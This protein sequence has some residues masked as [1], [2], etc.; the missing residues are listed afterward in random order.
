MSAGNRTAQAK[1]SKPRPDFPLFPHAVGRWTMKIRGKR[2]YFGPWNDPDGTEGKKLKERDHLHAG[3]KPREEVSAGVTVKIAC[4]CFLNS[5]QKKVD[6]GKMTK[7]S[8]PDHKTACDLIVTKLGKHRLVADLDP[9]DF[10]TLRAKMAKKWEPVTLGNVIQRSRT[11]FQFAV[12]SRMIPQEV[13][14]GD[15]FQRPNLQASPPRHGLL[16]RR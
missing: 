8:C 1:P 15:E 2:V 5:R 16:R 7:R 13:R 6:Y 11:V 14:H 9:D 12:K 3:K 4:N 10:T